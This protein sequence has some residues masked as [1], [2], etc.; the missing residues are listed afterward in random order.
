MESPTYTEW[1][2]TQHAVKAGSDKLVIHNLQFKATRLIAIAFES[3]L[4]CMHVRENELKSGKSFTRSIN[5]QSDVSF[6][7]FSTKS[8]SI[9]TLNIY[10]TSLTRSTETKKAGSWN[11]NLIKG[12]KAK[13]R[14]GLWHQSDACLQFSFTS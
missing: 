3:K 5:V 1:H 2:T 11:F 13:P 8:L 14:L 12:N 6:N 9:L 7:W 10:A 4:G